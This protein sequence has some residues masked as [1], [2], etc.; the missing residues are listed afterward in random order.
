MGPS[1]RTEIVRGPVLSH[2]LWLGRVGESGPSENDV[3]RGRGSGPRVSV[4][5]QGLLSGG[6]G[7]G[8]G[9]GG[10]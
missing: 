5:A 2:I 8:W 3:G 6:R 4:S 1:G 7:E 10:G 9:V